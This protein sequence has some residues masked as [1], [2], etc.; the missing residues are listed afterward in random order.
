[1]LAVRIHETIKQ[2]KR[3]ILLK[4]LNCFHYY[5]GLCSPCANNVGGYLADIYCATLA[6]RLH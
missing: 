4:K 3:P 1:M 5:A 6:R 2:I